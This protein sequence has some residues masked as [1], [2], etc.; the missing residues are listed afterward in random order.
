MPH[1]DSVDIV[2]KND[3]TESKSSQHTERELSILLQKAIGG[4]TPNLSEKQVDEVLSQRRKIA[5]F[6]HEDRQR[7][8]YDMKFYLIGILLFVLLFSGLVLWK[9]PDVFSEV[10]SLIVGLFGGGVGGYGIGKTK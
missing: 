5:E 7:D 2:T 6:V 3:S 9:K 8:S 4:D 1:N 10:L